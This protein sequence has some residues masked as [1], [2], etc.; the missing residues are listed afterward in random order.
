[1]SPFGSYSDPFSS[2]DPFSGL[3]GLTSGLSGIVSGLGF[4]QVALYIIIFLAVCVV[5]FLRGY[6]LLQTGRKAGVSKEYD[7]MP[8]VP[9]A[10]SAYRHRILGE[11]DWK[12][13]FW[14]DNMFYASAMV[15]FA[16][17]I[18]AVAGGGVPFVALLLMFALLYLFSGRLLT[19]FLWFF[20]TVAFLSVPGVPV[21]LVIYT[22]VVFLYLAGSLAYRFVYTKK[23]Y[24]AF[25]INPLFA[26]HIFVP[27]GGIIATV[28]EYLIAFSDNYRMG[29]GRREDPA[30]RGPSPAPA[31]GANQGSL[32]GL[33]GMYRNTTID[34][35]AGEEIMLG[36][37]AAMSQVIIDQDADNISRRHC[38]IRYN[39]DG[40][41]SVTDYST[42]GT[43]REDGSHLPSNMPVTLPR[44]TV[45]CLGSRRVSF[46]LG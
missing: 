41:Y 15:I 31:Y 7:W 27:F 33:S 19:L 42:N 11:P 18:G 39:P 40:T 29:G 44:G 13:L 9:F 35:P 6:A 2:L 46:R 21:G 43:F 32:F 20:M 10:Q 16:L 8:F 4:L 17:I 24:R 26:L 3:S 14:T 25:H 30:S 12:L 22:V 37:D 28:F 36:R 1:M 45:I 23:L 38:G 34:L 5:Y